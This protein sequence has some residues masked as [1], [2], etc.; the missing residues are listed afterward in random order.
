MPPTA[1]TIS[2]SRMG[3]FRSQKANTAVTTRP[4]KTAGPMVAHVQNMNVHMRLRLTLTS[5]CRV[6]ATGE[7]SFTAARR[8]LPPTLSVI[9]LHGTTAWARRRYFLR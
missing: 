9:L 8:R 6:I 2:A 3:G 1:I 7:A 5:D 4:A